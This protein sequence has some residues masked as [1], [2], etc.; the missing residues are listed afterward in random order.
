MKTQMLRIAVFA[1]A[2]LALASAAMAQTSSGVFVDVPFAFV[3]GNHHMQPGR[4]A[5]TPAANGFLRI[6]ET[7][8]ADNQL[9]LAV[10][11]IQSNTPQDAKLV[12][13]RYGDTYFLSEIWKGNSEIGRELPKS[14]E[15]KEIE[16]G[17]LNAPRPKA[18]VAEVRPER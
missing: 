12:F 11:S 8:V 3:A 17:R 9:F 16:L 1:M 4:Y 2:L 14:K 10:H 5:V 18:E 15:E 6:Y 13:H 7:G